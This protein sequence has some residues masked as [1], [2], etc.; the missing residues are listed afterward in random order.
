MILGAL[1]QNPL[2]ITAALPLRVFPPLF[3]RYQGGQSFGTHVDNAIRQVTGTPHRIRTDLS[4][5]LFFTGPEEYDGGELDGGG[6]LRHAQREAARR[7]H[8]SLSRPP[9]CITCVRSRGARASRRS[10][11]FKAWCATTASARCCSTSTWR[12]SGSIG[13]APIT[14]R[15]ATDR[16]LP[17]SAAALGRRLTD[18]DLYVGPRV[19][20]QRIWGLL[21]LEPR[22][23]RGEIGAVDTPRR[24]A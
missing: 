9:A 19:W 18:R 7:P 13:T 3:N 8:D 14:R 24:G 2:F 23:S 10:S 11:G 15:R 21:N 12:S 4:A 22:E 16:R 6:H 20:R 17:Q 5:T 1:G